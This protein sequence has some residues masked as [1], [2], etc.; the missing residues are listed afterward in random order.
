MKHHLMRGL[1]VGIIAIP[2]LIASCS[3][4]DKG[5]TPDTAPVLTVPQFVQAVNFVGADAAIQSAKAKVQ[6]EIA[7][8]PPL[9]A[10]AASLAT[11]ANSG[12]WGAKADGCWSKSSSQ[13]NCTTTHKVCEGMSGA[14]DWSRTL[15]GNCSGTDHSNWSAADGTTGADG[16]SGV[17][18]LYKDNTADVDSL[19]VWSTAADKN[20]KDWNV[21]H[22]T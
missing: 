8:A 11:A 14:Y 18:R 22:G 2:L 16:G 15:N 21:Y 19:W 3:K 10:P 1:V 13:G 17:L 6:S 9:F 7:L 20:S 12:Q 4:D 5:T